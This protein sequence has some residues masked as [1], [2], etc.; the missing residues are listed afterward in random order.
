MKD[1][2]NYVI[3]ILAGLLAFSMAMKP[4]TPT[5]E[6]E[7]STSVNQYDPVLLAEYSA[8]L[9]SLPTS[10][11]YYAG[12]EARDTCK[13]WYPVEGAKPPTSSIFKP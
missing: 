6:S 7:T 10:S 11:F 1:F 2:K 4:T 3:A 13:W 12:H 8:C 5:A 9:N